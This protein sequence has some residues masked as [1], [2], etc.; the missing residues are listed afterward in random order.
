MHSKSFIRA[1]ALAALATGLAHRADAAVLWTL[2]NVT[3]S[4]NATPGA[5]SGSFT[6]DATTNTFSNI[7]IRHSPDA[8]EPTPLTFSTFASGTASTLMLQNGAPDPDGSIGRHTLTLTFATPLTNINQTVNL[9]GAATYF[10]GLR[11]ETITGG[12]V[13]GTPEPASLSLAAIGSLVL[14]RRRR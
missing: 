10:T 13:V 9:G 11:S 8:T 1:I 12:T 14:L 3:E 2:T 6:Y 7:L 5:F 4:T